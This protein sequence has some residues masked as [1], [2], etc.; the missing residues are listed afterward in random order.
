MS[1]AP[2]PTAGQLVRFSSVAVPLAAAG[3]PLGV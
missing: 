3:L 2:P 1:G